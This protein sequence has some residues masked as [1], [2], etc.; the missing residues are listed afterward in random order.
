MFLVCIATGQQIF[1]WQGQIFSTLIGEH[2][3]GATLTVAQRASVI[4]SFA[5]ICLNAVNAPRFARYLERGDFQCLRTLGL[6][7]A[8]F[9]LGFA[10]LAAVLVLWLKEDV[11]SAFGT[12]YTNRS[13]ELVTLCIVQVFSCA[14]GPVGQI[15]L[16]AKNRRD[17]AFSFVISIGFGMMV[18]YS[19]TFIFQLHY[20]PL[21]AI[22]ATV[23][24]KNIVDAYY[25]YKLFISDK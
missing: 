20:G 9:S 7:S 17:S 18:L 19:A 15:L 2:E 25:V 6:R 21:W 14:F 11:M 1:I 10:I 22:C 4:V 8:S 23:G 16:M 13:F 12:A 5:Q 3:L 24:C